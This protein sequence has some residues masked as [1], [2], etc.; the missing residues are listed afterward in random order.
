MQGDSCPLPITPFISPFNEYAR[1][2]DPDII[3]LMVRASSDHSVKLYY[4]LKTDESL[5]D[6]AVE[7]VPSVLKN[8]FKFTFINDT[9]TVYINAS[10]ISKFTN[11]SFLVPTDTYSIVDGFFSQLFGKL[12][13]LVASQDEPVSNYIDFNFLIVDNINNTISYSIVSFSTIKEGFYSDA[14]KFSFVSGRILF[15]DSYAVM[16]I[17]LAFGGLCLSNI[18]LKYS[19]LNITF[20]QQMA[21]GNIFEGYS[22]ILSVDYSSFDIFNFSGQ[23][24]FHK[25][26]L[27]VDLMKFIPTTSE[28]SL[29]SVSKNSLITI[30]G[31]TIPLFLLTIFLVLVKRK[32]IF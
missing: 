20:I 32:K 6:L 4:N 27:K 31:L 11:I 15:N 8:D 23:L 24:M 7:T 30:A 1:T 26:F 28:S 25:E 3:Q 29:S 9:K 13:L 17:S 21:S 16:S 19:P 5:T 10:P 14:P 12:Y 22:S 2:I 18:F